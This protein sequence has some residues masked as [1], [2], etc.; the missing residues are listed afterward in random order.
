MNGWVTTFSS[1]SSSD[2]LTTSLDSDEENQPSII[3]TQSLKFQQNRYKGALHVFIFKVGQGNFCMIK[4]DEN[5]VI[6]DAGSH[7]VQR[8]DIVAFENIQN[9]FELCLNGAKVQAVIITHA[10]EDH[11]NF[12]SSLE[13]YMD[14]ACFF[15]LG[16]TNEHANSILSN[17]SKTSF[18][19]FYLDLASTDL[20]FKD[21]NFNLHDITKIEER[22]NSLIPNGFFNF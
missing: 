10:D 17:L 21:K 9:I 14:P 1:F 16:G 19:Y 18:F 3:N 22:L 20:K 5:A 7:S 2:S 6:I 13:Q 8:Q 15:V 12:L 11:Y 4:K